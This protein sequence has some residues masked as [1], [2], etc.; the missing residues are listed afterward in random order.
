MNARQLA[1]LNGRLAIALR[2]RRGAGAIGSD[3]ELT[4]AILRDKGGTEI[5]IA[6]LLQRL[7]PRTARRPP[8]I[9]VKQ[10]RDPKDSALAA[11][12]TDPK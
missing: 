2:A 8:G 3:E 4:N 11:T 5:D 12:T 7:H 10:R 9:H 6:P 1:A